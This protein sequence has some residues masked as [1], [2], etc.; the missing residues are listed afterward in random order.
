MSYSDMLHYLLSTLFLLHCLSLAA[1]SKQGQHNDQIPLGPQL[2]ATF[3]DIR[4]SDLADFTTIVMDAFSP[5]A[6]WKYMVP[7]YEK[8]KSE[9]W[10]CFHERTLQRWQEANK[11]TTFGKIISVP[12][13]ESGEPPRDRAVSL[14]I[15]NIRTRDEAFATQGYGIFSGLNCSS[16]PGMNMTRVMDLDRQTDK[17]MQKYIY[18]AYEKQLYL[19]LLATHPDWDGNGFAARQLGWGMELAKELD[20]PVTLFA[21]PAGWPVYDSVGFES[22]KNATFTLLDGLGT[23]WHEV[24]RWNY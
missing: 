5:S 6:E 11:T 3:R 18:R 16:P 14:A 8:H 12:F 23:V 10:Y 22:V 9:L 15:W 21:T 19:N 13:S 1:P 7:G 4:E 2:N 17:V 20:L 24:M